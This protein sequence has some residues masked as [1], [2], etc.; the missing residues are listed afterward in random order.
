MT[1]HVVPRRFFLVVV[2]VCW[3]DGRITAEIRP[4]SSGMV[5]ILLSGMIAA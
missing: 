4:Y 5:I 2:F 1:R 3:V